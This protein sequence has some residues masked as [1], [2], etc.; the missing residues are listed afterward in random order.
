MALCALHSAQGDMSDALHLFTDDKRMARLEE[1]K[2]IKGRRR[3]MEEK[4]IENQLG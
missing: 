3:G 4:K 2:R 1:E